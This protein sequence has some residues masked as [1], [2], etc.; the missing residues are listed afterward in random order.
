MFSI[1]DVEKGIFTLRDRIFEQ[2][3]EWQFSSDSMPGLA[4]LMEDDGE[5]PKNE[6]EFMAKM[7]SMNEEEQKDFVNKMRLRSK[8]QLAIMAS[9]CTPLFPIPDIF[10]NK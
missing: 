6:E 1:V 5:M 4:I 2:D 8:K 3:R 7:D 9:L 10:Q